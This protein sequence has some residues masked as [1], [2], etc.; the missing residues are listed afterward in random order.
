MPLIIVSPLSKRP[1]S[2]DT[3]EQIARSCAASLTASTYRLI[4]LSTW[5][6][7]MVW[8]VDGQAKWWRGSEEF[9]FTIKRGPLDPNTFAADCFAGGSVPDRFEEVSADGWLTSYNLKAG[10]MIKEHS[11]CLPNY[12]AALT[13]LYTDEF[14]EYKSD[15]QTD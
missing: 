3:A 9:P 2:F 4:E 10:A 8:S 6:V 15:Y 11:R 12:N 7:A 5:R 13:L 14:I 1:P